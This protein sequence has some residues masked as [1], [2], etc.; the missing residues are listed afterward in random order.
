MPI[1]QTIQEIKQ[2]QQPHDSVFS[3]LIYR[4]ISKR[5]TYVMLRMIPGISAPDVTIISFIVGLIGAAGLLY[6]DTGARIVAWAC[7]QL[8]FAFDC[9]DGEVARMTGRGSKFGIWFDSISD[10]TKEII[11]FLAIGIQLYIYAPVSS[12][13]NDWQVLLTQE[14]GGSPWVI[15]LAGTAA[16]GTLLVG[17]LRE[18]KKSIFL[19]ER[20]P[21]LV[22]KSGLH[23][24][25]VDVITFL[26]AWGALFHLE[27]YV[28]WM[29]LLP[30]PLLLAKQL[31]S[32]YRQSNK[33]NRKSVDGI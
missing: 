31:I 4:R 12:N 14:F 19:A 20:K 30:V 17:Y 3:R 23:I 18:A 22:L 2:Y 8:S 24:G 25:T 15:Y 21:E 29:V 6:P 7:I 10:R 13:P 28:L 16:L 1:P 32:T 33:P 5:L 26:L 27:Y 9:S 11:W